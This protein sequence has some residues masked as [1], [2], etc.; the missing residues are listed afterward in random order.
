MAWGRTPSEER[1]ASEAAELAAE[2]AHLR[3]Q[4]SPYERQVLELLAGIRD[5][6]AALAVV[7][8]EEPQTN[9]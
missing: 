1:A 3:A 2:R 9:P 8:R 4:M 5:A 7:E 6:L